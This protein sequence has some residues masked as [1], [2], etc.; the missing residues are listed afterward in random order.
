MDDHGVCIDECHADLLY[1][2]VRAHKSRSVLELGYGRGRSLKSIKRACVDNE[3][4][5]RYDLVDNWSDFGGVKPESA[6]EPG[7][8]FIVQDEGAFTRTFIGTPY[9][10]IFSDADHTHAQEW[11]NETYTSLL[12]NG[13][14]IAYHD[15][16]NFPNLYN[17]V[18]DCEAQSLNHV[19]F[20]KSSITGEACCRGLLVVFKPPK[21]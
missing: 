18:R 12:A 9:D 8:N 11:F 16:C 10:F 4:S 7:I 19:V 6:V 21:Q 14:I 1:G 13:G 3:I 20:N 15:V 2:L 17:I 5:A